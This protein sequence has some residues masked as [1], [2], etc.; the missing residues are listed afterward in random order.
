MSAT[1]L[2]GSINPQSALLPAMRGSHERD[3]ARMLLGKRSSL[4]VRVIVDAATDAAIRRVRRDVM[5][6]AKLAESARR[7]ESRDGIASLFEP[8]PATGRDVVTVADKLESTYARLRHERAQV[9]AAMAHEPSN[10]GRGSAAVRVASSVSALQTRASDRPHVA[11]SHDARPAAD[12]SSVRPY[13]GRRAAR[14]AQYHSNPP[15]RTIIGRDGKP[16]S[17]ECVSVKP[18]GSR[19]AFVPPSDATDRRKRASRE[20]RSQ[21]RRVKL[22]TLATTRGHTD[23]MLT[24]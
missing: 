3:D 10:D 19:E 8:M 21:A 15:R 7:R 12:R 2:F 16:W 1:T 9:I 4:P 14:D 22:A 5:T 13:S 23:S 17:F 18:D 24:V 6:A 20:N 11:D